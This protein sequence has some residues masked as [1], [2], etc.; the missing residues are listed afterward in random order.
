MGWYDVLAVLMPG[1]VP[2]TN[3]I[4]FGNVWALYY[5]LAMLLRPGPALYPVQ[6]WSLA[7]SIVRVVGNNDAKPLGNIW[8]CYQKSRRN[9][10][11]VRVG[12][13]SVRW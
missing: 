1:V 10:H 5:V 13:V 9:A 2:G 4:L 6:I 7:S 11:S 3:A 8:T 12:A